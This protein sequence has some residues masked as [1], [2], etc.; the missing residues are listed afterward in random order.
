[1]MLVY[2]PEFKKS[3]LKLPQQC[4]EKL[5]RLL[6]V[7]AENMHSPLLHA[8]RLK[9]VMSGYQ[10]FRITRDWRV[11]FIL[12]DA[13]LIHLVRVEHRKDAYR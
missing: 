1:M 8:K 11:I 6:V 9:G 12:V 7:L 5:S 3:F 4:Q 13:T 10:S 2:G